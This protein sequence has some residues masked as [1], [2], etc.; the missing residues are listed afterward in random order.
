MLASLRNDTGRHFDY[1]KYGHAEGYVTENSPEDGLRSRILQLASRISGLKTA[2]NAVLLNV[3][4]PGGYH[5]AH[6]DSVILHVVKEIFCI[7]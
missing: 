6:I 4:A 1:N 3:H 5:S 7:H 2:D